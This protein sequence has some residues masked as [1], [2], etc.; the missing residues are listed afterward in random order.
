[1]LRRLLS[2]STV[3]LAAVQGLPFNRITESDVTHT[4]L[5]I[6]FK[7]ISDS[8]WTSVSTNNAAWEDGVV[9]FISLPSFGGSHYTEGKM[10][11]PKMEQEAV[12]N[13]DGT[14]TFSVKL[15]QANDSF[16]SRD[17][18]TP[19]PLGDVQLS[20]MVIERGVYFLDGHSMIIDKGDISRVDNSGSATIQN[21]NAVRLNYP[22]GCDGDFVTSCTTTD[23]ADKSELG[24]LQQLQT[25]VN[26]VDN[27]Q[28]LFLSV[29]TRFVNIRH[30]QLVMFP[31]SS[32]DA[33][34]FELTTP[35][36]IG[37]LVFAAF[38]FI[39]AEN[40]VF[41]TAIH[42]GVTHEPIAVPFFHNFDYVPGLFGTLGSTLSLIDA[43][44]IRS[45][46][47]TTVGSNFITQED[48]CDTEQSSHEQPELVFTM[49]VGEVAGSE[50]NF[51]CNVI[52]NSAVTTSDPSVIP[53]V[54]PS[55]SPTITPTAVPSA[56][57]TVTPSAS[58]TNRP[59]L[60][61]SER[62]TAP[63][64]GQCNAAA[65]EVKFTKTAKTI[66]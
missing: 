27:G 32:S 26:T 38:E 13:G 36:V 5:E 24:A 30:I 8:H 1:M 61:P 25:S 33:S 4:W 37:Y 48:Q 18:Y 11:A 28:D 64:T 62:E 29:R 65:F 42:E 3:L 56:S 54:A 34:S 44:I 60:S 21:G 20:W 16:C 53:S 9:V 63:P 59:T 41:E 39:C 15:V 51:S 46:N 66:N 17:F 10:I 7:T 45:F 22:V 50:S 58:P 12:Q 49:V 43:T 23:V 19:T 6:G 57:P 55:L 52:F 40:L 31:H 35:E 47:S 14:Y 2:I